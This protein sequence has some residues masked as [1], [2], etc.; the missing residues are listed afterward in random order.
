MD[1]HSHLSHLAVG[2]TKLTY[3]PDRASPIV[4]DLTTLPPASIE[5]LL[6]MGMTAY[7]GNNTAAKIS[8]TKKKV[9]ASTGEM[10]SSALAELKAQLLAEAQ[11]DLQSG[12]FG[13]TRTPK[14]ETAVLG[15]FNRLVEAKARSLLLQRGMTLPIGTN[16]IEFA[17]PTEDNPT[18]V[19]HL[20][21][22][23]L[24]ARTEARYGAALRTEA[25]EIYRK[26][27]AAS[28]APMAVSALGF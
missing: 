6:H 28:E 3:A 23:N 2:K 18:G 10:T 11:E 7:F 26:E 15:I 16:T 14:G 4:V 1:A 13:R 9:E 21:R 17:N 27:Q 19:V 24:L 20:T 8:Q 25:E 22:A 5:K 12:E